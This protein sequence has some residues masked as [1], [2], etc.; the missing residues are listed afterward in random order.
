MAELKKGVQAVAK[1]PRYVTVKELA[2][3]GKWDEAQDLENQIQ[4]D[5][6]GP[7]DPR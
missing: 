3:Q 5:I 4:L 7:K 2:A 6:L 1:D